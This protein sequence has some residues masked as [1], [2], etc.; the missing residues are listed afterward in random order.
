MPRFANREE[1]EAWK[2]GEVVAEGSVPAAT[3]PGTP[4]AVAPQA[5][6]SPGAK[7]KTGLKETLSGLPP[8]AWL[9]V[10]A[11]IALPV[12]NLGGAIP[13][14]LGFGGAAG[15]AN[16]AKKKEWEL[17]PRVLVCGL[18]T[19]GIWILFFGFAVAFV[20]MQK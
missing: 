16:V 20:R 15:C 1:Y 13:G 11:C 4:P 7:P 3:S 5:A 14:A 9:F 17:A 19:A 10:A 18:I 6:A 8:W 2:R 12:I